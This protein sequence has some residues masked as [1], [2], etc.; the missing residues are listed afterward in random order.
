M[1]SPYTGKEMTIVQEPR[2]WNFR[3]E[4]FEYLHTAYRCEDTGEQ[5]T[6][7]ETDDASFFEVTNKYRLKYGLPSTEEIIAIRKRYKVSALKMSTILGF[8][9][10]QWRL[11]ENGEV[12]SISNGR[13][14]RAIRKPEV[15][16]DLIES[17][18]NQLTAKEYSRM[19]LH[20]EA[21]Q[22]SLK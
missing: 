22:E 4:K 12:P 10:N 7:S 15:F 20:V 2:I 5:F 6:T 13:L 1:K 17:A 11:Y 8:G 19:V 3:G 18:R 16:L 21:M 9:A 14:I